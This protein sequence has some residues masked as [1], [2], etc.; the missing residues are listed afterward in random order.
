MVCPIFLLSVF[1]ELGIFFQKT[2]ARFHQIFAQPENFDDLNAKQPIRA[3]RTALRDKPL[4]LERVANGGEVLP[5]G[6]GTLRDVEHRKFGSS[7]QCDLR[8]GSNC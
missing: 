4:S 7:H 2:K 5:F 8:I 6:V 1:G 3:L